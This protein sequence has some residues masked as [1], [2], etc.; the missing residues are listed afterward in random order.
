MGNE[1][2]EMKEWGKEEGEEVAVRGEAKKKV[3]I[4]I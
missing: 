2:G 3:E 4:R 1:G